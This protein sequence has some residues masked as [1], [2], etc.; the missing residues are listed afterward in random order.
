M[1]PNRRFGVE[2]ECHMPAGKTNR[3]LEHYLRAQRRIAIQYMGY[4]HQH[5]AGWKIV[6]DRSLGDDLDYHAEIVSPPLSGQRGLERVMTIANAVRDFGCHVDVKCGLHVHVEA[7]DLSV[8]E[9]RKVAVNFVHCES[10]FDAI[11]PPSRRGSRNDYVKSNRAAF[12][13]GYENTAINR[14]IDAY[15]SAETMEQLIQVVSQAGDRSVYNANKFRKLNLHPMTRQGTIEFRQHAG[16]VESDKIINWIELCVTFV[17]RAK[18]SQPRK[19]TVMRRQKISH[20]LSALLRWLKLSDEARKFFLERAKQF[21][22]RALIEA[23]YAQALVDNVRWD[24]ERREA[25][26]QLAYANAWRENNHMDYERR[27]QERIRQRRS[28]GARRAWQTRRLRE[29]EALGAE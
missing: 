14:A 21:S 8:A 11:M 20:E 29:L 10:A 19:R 23:A 1:I 12:G 5:T 17:E 22:D 18:F 6:T 4:T 25:E 7:S 16:T 2:I 26:M 9:V 15:T 3:D 27:R 13:G 28:E 24:E